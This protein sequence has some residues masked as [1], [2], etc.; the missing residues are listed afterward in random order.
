MREE[1]PLVDRD[2]LLER[3]PG[4]GGWTF[5]FIPEI[6]PDPHAPFGWVKVR[7]SVDGVEI[8]DYHLMPG[9]HGS[10]QL[11]LS[12]KAE[13]RRKI[14][15]GDGDWVRVVLYR[16]DASPEV[17]EELTLCLRDDH[18]AERFFGSLSEGERNKYV[19]WINSAKTERTKVDR[20]ARTIDALSN[21]LRFADR[22]TGKKSKSLF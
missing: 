4:K 2:Y 18:A 13:L 9:E 8:S 1:K 22:P 17:P 20:I 6:A 11:F 16:D 5:T 21:G 12:V 15:K 3:M 10:K 14:K 19:R 7:G